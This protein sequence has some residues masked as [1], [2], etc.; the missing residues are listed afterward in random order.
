MTYALAF[1]G[2][3]RH[4]L[5]VDY[6]QEKIEVAKNCPDSTANLHFEHGD[7]TNFAYG[8]SDAFIISDVLHYL[9]PEEQL[10][11]LQNM[12][13]QL[14]PGGKIIIR[15]G[16]SSKK[17][18]HKGTQLTEIFSTGIGFNKTTHDLH[19]ISAEMIMTFADEN[20][21][22]LKII[23][24]TKLTSNTVFVLTQKDSDGKI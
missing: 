14:N 15:D 22:T 19:Y 13:S 2:K 21:L 4:L 12:V 6:D 7:V 5:G 18:R 1:S 23:D 20:N 8:K 24:N 3:D 9:M 10:K 17:A 16:N 11:V